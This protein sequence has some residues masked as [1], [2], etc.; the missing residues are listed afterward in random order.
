MEEKWISLK[1]NLKFNGFV[2]ICYGTAILMDSLQF[3]M[4]QQFYTKCHFLCINDLQL[5]FT[6][7][8]QNQVT[9]QIK[10]S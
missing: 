9:E 8:P 3:A 10:N 1:Q 4:E 5:H 6:Y 2:T 7:N